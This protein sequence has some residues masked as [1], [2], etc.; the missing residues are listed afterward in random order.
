[1]KEIP[2]YAK[3]IVAHLEAGLQ[4][5]GEVKIKEPNFRQDHL[6]DY[7][8]AGRHRFRFDN[9]DK[10]TGNS[11]G[12]VSVEWNGRIGSKTPIIYVFLDELR[13]RK[14]F[15][16]SIFN[17]VLRE[18]NKNDLWVGFNHYDW[19]NIRLRLRQEIESD[20][21]AIN[22]IL[23]LV[24]DYEQLDADPNFNRRIKE[25]RESERK[26][27]IEIERLEKRKRRLTCR[28]NNS[29]LKRLGEGKKILEDVV[30]E[31]K[32]EEGE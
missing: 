25:F 21:L 31:Q 28:L 11:R 2:D 22:Q 7:E 27:E 14:G 8:V 19:S 6:I 13:E 30:G 15:V 29:V 9:L 10:Y 12:Y 3:P 23:G 18:E 17:S 20:K 1:M 16:W 24:R 26:Y 4:Q 5:F 32:E